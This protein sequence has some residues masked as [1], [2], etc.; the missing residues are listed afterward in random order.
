MGNTSTL[1]TTYQV[2]TNFDNSRQQM[3]S[4]SLSSQLTPL[5]VNYG[6]ATTTTTSVDG[7][8]ITKVTPSQCNFYRFLF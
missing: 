5:N 2:R 6:N 1:P 7:I 3:Q 4:N 8:Q